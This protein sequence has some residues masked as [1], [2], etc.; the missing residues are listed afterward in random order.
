MSNSTL[1]LLTTR[2]FAPLFV[3]QFLGA[4]ND[5]VFKNAL[6]ILMLYRLAADDDGQLLVTVAAGVFVLPFFLFSATAGQIADKYEKSGLIRRIKFAE[7]LI[8]GLAVGGLYLGDITLLFGVLFLTGMQSTFFGP[9][10][11]GI[12]PDHLH[13]NE[14]ISGNGLIEAGTFIATLVGTVIGGIFILQ[15]AGLAIVSTI[16]LGLAILGWLASQTVPKAPVTAVSIRVNP[17]FIV[18]TWRV[19]VHAGQRRNL[20]LPILGISWYWLMGTTLL[21]QF[22][23]LTKAVLG[24]N[25]EVVTLLLTAFAIGIGIG[26]TLCMKLLN[27]EVSARFVPIAAIAMTVFVSD[28]YLSVADRTSGSSLIG[29]AVF[30][31]RP[32]NWRI[33]FDLLAI[34]VASGLYSV[35]L[36]AI[37]QNESAPEH[38]ARNAA[39]NNVVNSLFM[40]VGAL[41]AGAMLASDIRVP[42]VLLSIAIVNAFVAL[43]VCRLL[44]GQLTGTLLA[45]LMRLSFQKVTKRLENCHKAGKRWRGRHVTWI[46]AGLGILIVLVVLFVPPIPQDPAY[47]DFADQ[48][49][50]LGIE[51]FADAASNLAFLLAGGFGLWGVTGARSG[52][53]FEDRSDA[54]PYRVFFIGVLLIGAGSSCYHAAPDNERLLWDRLAMSFAFMAFLSA[55]IADRIGRTAGLT[56]A[57]PI[58]IALGI[59]SLVYWHWSE[60]I[61][62]GDLRP[63]AVI[64][65]A[66]AL[67]L[68]VMC[69][70]YP[71]RRYTVGRFLAVMLGLFLAA[72]LFEHFDAEILSLTGQVI[73]GHALKHFLA[74]IACYLPLAMLRRAALEQARLS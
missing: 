73:G 48:W 16:V 55:V 34:A 12:L 47:H 28:L 45:I 20:L 39:A 32:E 70:L 25:Q 6:V 57:L 46:L 64:Q 71:D 9:L 2:R 33:L 40:V 31:A 3:T 59:A 68:P 37:L 15:N 10:K 1:S 18:E 24:G 4:M 14:L 44:P 43:F 56:W 7:I 22:P 27:G 23:N 50:W 35:P 41:W 54:V 58:G 17:N 72:K 61:G 65:F 13:E 60:S 51:R 74:A 42:G 69:I 63:Y 26:A 19:I 5:N 36:Y 49:V 30:A 67:F 53:L 38:R 62:Q 52:K 8:M 66:P 11:Y 21:T 29:A